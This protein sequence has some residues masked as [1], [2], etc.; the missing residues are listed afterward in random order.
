MLYSKAMAFEGVDFLGLEDLL[1]NEDRRVRVGVR[2]FVEEQLI[3]IIEDHYMMGT[4]PSELI[5]SLG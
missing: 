2:S 5:R 3:P 4:C 1:R